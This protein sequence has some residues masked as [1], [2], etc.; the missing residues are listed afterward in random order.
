MTC[1]ND[2]SLKF[3][4]SF[5]YGLLIALEMVLFPV[6]GYS[7]LLSPGHACAA[8]SPAVPHC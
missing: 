7:Y 2:R 1:E 6:I 8:N 5:F 4:E 3:K